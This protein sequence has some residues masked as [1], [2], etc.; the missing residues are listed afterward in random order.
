MPASNESAK[1]RLTH[2]RGQQREIA[3][4]LDDLPMYSIGAA[5][6]EEALAIAS[7]MVAHYEP[8][9]AKSDQEADAGGETIRSGAHLPQATAG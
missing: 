5:S 7:E 6:L 4:M 2:W 3:Q 9:A 1:E 8:L